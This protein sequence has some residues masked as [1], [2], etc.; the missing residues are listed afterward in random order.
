MLDDGA[1]KPHYRPT[2]ED[3]VWLRYRLGWYGFQLLLYLAIVYRIGPNLVLFHSPFSPGPEDYVAFTNDYVPIIAAIKAYSRDFGQLPMDSLELP[4]AY[5]PRGN[6]GQIGEILG[7]TSI[8]FQVGDN[9]VLEYEFSSPVEGWIVH[10]PRYDGRI[11]A[12]I[13]PAAPKP[14]TR[15]SSSPHTDAS[16]GN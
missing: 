12:P 14:V 13:V 7:T 1:R 15:P 3:R 4:P 6:N 8:T 11:P 10:A 16:H 5:R 2:P 9:A